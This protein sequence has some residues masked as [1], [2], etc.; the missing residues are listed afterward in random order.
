[1]IVNATE[2]APLEVRVGQAAEQ[3]GQLARYLRVG[4]VNAAL[5][6]PTRVA[7]FTQGTN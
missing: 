2:S 5:G 7:A 3:I 1:M 6:A 4:P